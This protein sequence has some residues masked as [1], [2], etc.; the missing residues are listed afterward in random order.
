MEGRE[1][2]LQQIEICKRFYNMEGKEG[3]EES[4]ILKSIA[5]FSNYRT[6]WTEAVDGRK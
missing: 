3:F 2:K 6:L 1:N 4:L 5:A